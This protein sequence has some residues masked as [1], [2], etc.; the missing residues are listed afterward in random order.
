MMLVVKAGGVVDAFID[1]DG[2][3]AERE[4]GRG[5]VMLVVKAG[6]VV[7]DFIDQMVDILKEK[8]EEVR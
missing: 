2:R 4:V 3:Y 7:D 1:S 6:G 5:E 8:G